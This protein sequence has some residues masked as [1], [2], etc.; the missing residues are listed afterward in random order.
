MDGDQVTA[1]VVFT[2]EA[3]AEIAQFLKSKKFYIDLGG[4]NVRTSSNESIQTLYN[5]TLILPG[6]NLTEPKF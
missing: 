3:N 2:D 4:T 1:K 5:L 6:S